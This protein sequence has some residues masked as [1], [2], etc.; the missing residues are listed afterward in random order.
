M[1]YQNTG[2]D[3]DGESESN[4]HQTTIAGD[5]G[6]MSSSNN[7][8]NN[9]FVRNNCGVRMS[10]NQQQ[11]SSARNMLSAT[12]GIQ[13]R[14]ASDCSSYNFGDGTCN[15]INFNGPSFTAAMKRGSQNGGGSTERRNSQ[16]NKSSL[17]SSS[18]DVS[19]GT[20]SSCSISDDSSTS[21]GQ[22]NLPYPGFVEFSFKYLSQDTRLRN[23]CLQL[24]TN[25]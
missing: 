10:N 4:V 18:D 9:S 12:S 21:S 11:V 20:H 23:W 7:N 17:S 13:R 19:S 5:K 6:R 24:I 15:N 3:S 16:N 14:R 25:P 2:S 22:P 8:N 1:I